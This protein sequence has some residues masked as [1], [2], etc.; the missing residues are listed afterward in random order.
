MSRGLT[1]FWNAPVVSEEEARNNPNPQRPRVVVPSGSDAERLLRAAQEGRI[2]G[3]CKYC[4]LR[5]GQELFKDEQLF[6]QL[7]DKLAYNHNQEWYGR[8]DLFAICKKWDSHM[9]H[10]Y[11]P[12]RI[13]KHFL[14]SNCDVNDRD[15]S[16]ECPHWEPKGSGMSGGLHYVG[17]RRNHEE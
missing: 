7:F 9:V 3:H 5:E 1:P 6:E 11:A 2:C 15:E 14:S 4:R 12:A 17:K 13:P 10:L 16:V 8:T